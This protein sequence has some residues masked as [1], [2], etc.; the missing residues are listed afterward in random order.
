MIMSVSSHERKPTE[1]CHAN[2]VSIANLVPDPALFANRMLR[3]LRYQ[4]QPL[5]KYRN[6]CNFLGFLIFDLAVQPVVVIT[7]VSRLSSE[8]HEPR[9]PFFVSMQLFF[10]CNFLGEITKTICIERPLPNSIRIPVTGDLLHLFCENFI[11]LAVYQAERYTRTDMT[12]WLI[13]P[14]PAS[15]GEPFSIRL[16]IA[17]ADVH[18]LV[19][20]AAEQLVCPLHTDKS[21]C[22][23]VL[24]H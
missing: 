5:A 13:P 7:V 3:L 24:S 19:F 20:D 11:S 18:F 6:L 10:V 4:N 21:D 15:G 1:F 16:L 23:D 22:S 17:S 9:S 14:A 2:H 12:V 8:L